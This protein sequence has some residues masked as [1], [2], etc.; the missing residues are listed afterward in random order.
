MIQFRRSSSLLLLNSNSRL[1]KPLYGSK[2]SDALPLGTVELFLAACST[3]S[4]YAPP[5]LTNFVH[6][7]VKECWSWP[8]SRTMPNG[9]S[10]D[11]RKTTL[12]TTSGKDSIT[13]QKVPPLA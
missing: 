12:S 13:D 4:G 8:R 1:V 3:I 9:S 7:Q 6:H 10:D 5:L 11:L 2:Q